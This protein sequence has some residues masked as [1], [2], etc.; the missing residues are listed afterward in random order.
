LAS[1]RRGLSLR[2]EEV[3][4]GRFVDENTL[5]I[6]PIQ[7][8]QTIKDHSQKP[9]LSN[10]DIKDAIEE[11][12]Q[13]SHDLRHICCGHDLASILSVG[14]R[15]AFGSN[16]AGDVKPDIIERSLRLAFEDVPFS[17]SQLYQSLQQW[18]Q[19]NPPYKVLRSSS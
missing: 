17:N 9:G 10:R 4:F 14:L 2:F 8:I 18:E 15:K 7:L 16:N 6:D 19:N 5:K 12:Q 1:L 3:S 11:I 13:G